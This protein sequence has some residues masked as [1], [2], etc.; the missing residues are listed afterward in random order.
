MRNLLFLIGR[1]RSKEGSLLK[2]ADWQRFNEAQSLTAWLKLLKDTD[3]QAAAESDNFENF[4]A[5][6]NQQMASLKK[7]L[8]AT[9]R[10]P[11]EPLLWKKY[12]FHNYKIF[13]KIHLGHKDLR[14]YLIPFGSISLDM[15]EAYLLKKEKVNIPLEL[16]IILRKAQE[17]FEENNKFSEMDVFLDKEYYKEI[18]SESKKWGKVI[19]D[20]FKL[21]IDIA[22]FKIWWFL[23]KDNELKV[24]YIPGGSYPPRYFE[25]AEEQTSEQM[26]SKIFPQIKA[27]NYMEA[28][29]QKDMDDNSSNYLF[30]RR[31]PNAS[32][33]P[34]LVYFRAKE[35][36]IKNLKT[37]YLR[38]AK[39]YKELSRYMRA[40]YV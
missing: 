7:E 30:Q 38:Q 34:V 33:L 21:Q 24:E 20:Y 19:E 2:D 22:N 39:N 4:E 31:Y 40:I 27:E 12:D 35:I 29:M 37:F 6:L 16:M 32:I 14:K 9:Q 5:A 17:I 25:L 3:Y 8:F 28:F 15:L 10:Y 26:F 23:K 18:L 13:L 11:F 1:V 36:E